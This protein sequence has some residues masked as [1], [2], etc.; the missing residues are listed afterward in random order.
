LLKCKTQGKYAYTKEGKKNSKVKR[1]QMRLEYAKALWCGSEQDE[2][3]L[4]KEID[5]RQ[6]AYV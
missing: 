2:R 6:T 5:A 3:L 4:T 1:P